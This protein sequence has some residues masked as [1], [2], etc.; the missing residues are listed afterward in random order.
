[1]TVLLGFQN[2]MIDL[3]ANQTNDFLFYLQPFGGVGEKNVFLFMIFALCYVVCLIWNTAIIGIT[4]ADTRLHIPMYFFL[5]NLSLV[6]ICYSTVTVPKLLDIF[7][8]GDNSISF[9]YCFVQFY[10][11]TA[12]AC[13]EI[14]LLTVMAYD[15]YVAICKSL[16]YPLVMNQNKCV[17]F[18]V[19]SW[20]SGYSNSLFVTI[21]ASKIPFCNSKAID[22]L[23]CDIKPMLKISCGNTWTTEVTVYLETF[24][25]GFCPFLCIMLS[26]TKIIFNVLRVKSKG[27]RSKTFST[28]TSHL[29]IILIFYGTLFFVYVMPSTTD[30]KTIVQVFSSLFLVVI[31]SLNPLI[32]SLRNKDMRTAFTRYFWRNSRKVVWVQ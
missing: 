30:F 22:Q 19:A 26:Y 5:R 24:F 2:A 18:V 15:R 6:D 27:R 25:M 32:Y 9:G 29:T 21:V 17:V 14:V 7:L 31:P 13:T 23:Y 8:R 12:L 11:F 20:A 1:M 10:F 4:Y 28:C 3:M 16:H